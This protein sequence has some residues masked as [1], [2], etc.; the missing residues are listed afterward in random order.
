MRRSSLDLA[1]EDLK[2]AEDANVRLAAQL[3]AAKQ[4]GRAL[5]EV[6]AQ[7]RTDQGALMLKVVALAEKGL[8]D[9]MLLRREGFNPPK[10][11]AAI[12]FG[13]D[14][15]AVVMDAILD[16]A[17]PGSDLYAVLVGWAKREL[18]RQVPV[19]GA[20]AG[21]TED[22]EPNVV[23]QHIRDGEDLSEVLP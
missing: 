17:E 14:V 13:P 21:E 5:E 6:L 19:E 23:A 15:P 2:A 11:D 12:D 16:R 18:K 20:E 8:D 1:W 10:P 3:E 4:H 22:I 7:F 9:V